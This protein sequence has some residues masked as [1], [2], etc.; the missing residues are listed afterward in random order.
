MTHR[1]EFLS[2]MAA[3][4][5]TFTLPTFN[6]RAIR[7]LSDAHA[8]AGGRAAG[9]L[10]DDENYWS[11]IQ[12]AFD[13]D[14]TMINLNNGGC[15]PAP[16]HVL[17]QMLR[18]LR[19]SN[20]LPVE[21]M[22]GVLE[23]RIESVR[24]ELARDFGCDPEEMAIVRNASEANETMIMGLDLQRGD[25]VIL[26]TQNYPRMQNAWKQRERRDGIVIRWV[27]L[28]TPPRSAGYYVDQIASAITPRTKVIETMH[29]SFMTGYIAPVKQIVDMARPKGIQVFVDGAHAYAH[30]PFTRDD[31]GADYYGTSLH[32]W[33]MA[34]I[35]TGFLYVRRDRIKSL[36]PLMAGAIEQEDNIR[37]YE[38]IGTHPAANHNA[39]AVALAFHRSIGAE[40]KIARL[41]YLRDRWA[42]RVVAESGGRARMLTPIGPNESGA[43][44]VV[45][46]DG[47]D[48]GKLQA[49]LLT[50]H[51]IV[52]TP[53]IH[54]EFSGLR[55]TPNVYT[56][57]EE[58]DRFAETLLAGIKNGLTA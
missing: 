12:R 21:H 2:S 55:V 43:I 32:K 37:K 34:P 14:R 30:F 35:G 18:D 16:T 9:N 3:A 4:A 13:L 58:V 8:I 24:R 7:R 36:W 50:R 10:A 27:K 15:S 22:W 31:L 57:L 49:W 6:P 17:E 26:T 51:H 20:E 45:S 19:F 53:L 25:E 52:A 29:I 44:G 42:K 40:R 1:R 41:R 54:A 23:P 38:E 33:L 11:E 39:I 47:V 56:T 28:E 46:I 5:A 48:I